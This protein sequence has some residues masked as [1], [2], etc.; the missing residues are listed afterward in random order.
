MEKTIKDF[1]KLNFTL[2]EKELMEQNREQNRK[3][4]MFVPP[5]LLKEERRIRL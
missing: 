1:F 5:I 3:K 2:L 4:I